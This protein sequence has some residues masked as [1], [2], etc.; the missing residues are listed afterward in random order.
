MKRTILFLATLFLNLVI[1]AQTSK[2]VTNL[3]PGSLLSQMTSD[4]LSTIKYLSISGIIDTRD[5]KTMRDK[6]P[7]LSVVDMMGVTIAEYTGAEGTKGNDTW[8]YPADVLPD[9]AFGNSLSLSS[10]E[11]PVSVTSIGDGAFMFCDKL[12]YIDIPDSVRS[13]NTGAFNGC[14]SLKWVRIPSSVTF[15]GMKAFMNCSSLQSFVIP[16]LVT[17]LGDSIFYNCTQ[18]TTIAAYPPNPVELPSPTIFY[19]VDKTTCTLHV[20][21]KSLSLYQS[22]DVWKDFLNVI[23]I[24]QQT[25]KTIN[26]LTPGNLI[27]Q[28]DAEELSIMESLT[29]SGTIDA[30]DFKTMR[31]TMPNLARVDLRNITIAEYTGEEGTDQRDEYN[32]IVTYPANTV[33]TCAFE[34]CDSLTSVTLPVSLTA[35]GIAAFEFC[36]HLEYVDI[37][38][39]V[40]SIGNVAFGY[41]IAL[42]SITLPSSLKTIGAY[43]F[44]Y[45]NHL[46]EITLPSSVTTLGDGIFQNCTQLTSII[47]PPAVTS[48]GDSAFGQCSGLKSVYIPKSVQTIGMDAFS[49]CDSLISVVIPNSVTSIKAYAFSNCKKLIS[50]VL[51][52]S[53]TS[54][55]DGIFYNCTQLTS[56]TAY[57]KTP[58]EL[59]S[60]DVFN[61]VDKAVC[62]L[63]VPAESLNLYHSATVWKDFLNV[64]AIQPSTHKTLALF[65]PGSLITRLTSEELSAI[66]S[67]TLSGT[68]DA[69]DF[70]I[71]RDSIPNLAVVDLT[72]VTI[73][74][75]SGLLGTRGQWARD[76]PADMTPHAAFEDKLSLTTVT[77][78]SSIHTIDIAS[79]AGCSNLSSVNIPSS[80]TIIGTSAFERCESLTSVTFPKTVTSIGVDAFRYCLKLKSISIPDSV[81]WIGDGAFSGCTSLTSITIPPVVT[82]IGANA[83]WG[84]N[85]IKKISI[86]ASVKQIGNTAFMESSIL[87]NVAFENKY[88]MSIDGVLFNKSQTILFYCPN[89]KSG[90]YIIPN[91][92]KTIK[93]EAFYRCERL[94]SV[95]MPAS[96]DSIGIRAFCLCTGLTKMVIPNSVKY[97]GDGAFDRCY[98]LASI[99]IPDSLSSIEGY[100][101]YECRSLRSIDIPNSVKSIGN[102]SF[103]NCWEL[104]SVTFPNSQDTII[105]EYAFS[106][107]CKLSS[108][109]IPNSVKT[110]KKGAFSSSCNLSSVTIPANVTKMEDAIFSNCQKLSKIYAYPKVPVKLPTY[111][112]F[113]YV[114]KSVCTL[115][116][117]VGSLELYKTSDVWQDFLKMEGVFPV[118]VEKNKS[119]LVTVWP[120]P[121]K[122]ALYIAGATGVVSIYNSNGRLVKSQSLEDNG[123]IAI[124]S[125]TSGMYVLVVDGKSFKIVKE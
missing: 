23:T 84:C 27:T 92:V 1:L 47:I 67:L 55:G 32:R 16:A 90:N 98:A 38:R 108:F 71:M 18:L 51:P 117:P 70:T 43:T 88:Y 39:S 94:T 121:A 33:P 5:F 48:I 10:V 31:D 103:S 80:V 19:G 77:L 102:S 111:K 37:P 59:P 24:P 87:I 81:N 14:S 104:K 124:S 96:V 11:L 63:Y 25:H 2:S 15:I 79:F 7:E 97:I 120:N 17:S 26:N 52:A 49:N 35:I 3:T 65:T 109:T 78:P 6:M 72:D 83:F 68:I 123:R 53:V 113:E 115:Y 110:I 95:A 41:C 29:L 22:A 42:T 46:K 62:T 73:A 30:R 50:V 9:F 69:S 89:S 93:N 75:Y 76:Y 21:V 4:E 114:D 91:T 86:P 107:G 122:D 85:G 34:N 101:F 57:P 13:I 58:V 74:K 60:P 99:N 44:L 105:G 40:T 82:Y 54:L 66:D 20:P 118:S 61:G 56:I 12:Y 106:G 45:C 125:L 8:T 112:V 28:M 100:T 119:S 116:V 64:N 36:K